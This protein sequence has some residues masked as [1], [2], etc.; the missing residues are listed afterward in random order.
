LYLP[1]KKGWQF[2]QISTVNEPR[3]DLVSTELPQAQV[4]RDGG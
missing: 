1:V 3:V 4:T 2:E